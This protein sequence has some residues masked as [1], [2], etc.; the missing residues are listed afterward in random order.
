MICVFSIIG[1][2]ISIYSNIF[3]KPKVRRSLYSFYFKLFQ[4]T[5]SW[6][7][8]S[9]VKFGVGGAALVGLRRD[10]QNGIGWSWKG[11]DLGKGQFEMINGIEFDFNCICDLIISHLKKQT[12]TELR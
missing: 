11:L 4:A 7:K 9:L 3:Y 2:H 6:F 10:G 5:L 12:W 8:L 1:E